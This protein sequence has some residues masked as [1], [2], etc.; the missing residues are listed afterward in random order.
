[1]PRPKGPGR[2][3]KI[4]TIVFE[5]FDKLDLLTVR[6]RDAEHAKTLAARQLDRRELGEIKPWVAIRMVL[7]GT[8]KAI[9]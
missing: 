7:F 1:M 2:G 3:Y 9:G 8:A 5:Q 4:F 6:A